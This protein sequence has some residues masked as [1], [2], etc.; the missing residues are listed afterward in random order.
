MRRYLALAIGRIG[1]P[2][3]A[4]VLQQLLV[5]ADSGVQATAA[6]SLGMLRDTSAL[7]QLRLLLG[8]EA[9]SASPAAR[10]EAATAVCRIGGTSAAGLIADYLRRAGGAAGAVA[11][12]EA[13]LRALG[14]AWRL[15]PLA[16]VDAII[17]F[18]TAAQ[19]DVRWHAVYSLARLKSAAA[20]S[21][22]LGATDDS[23]PGVRAIA[24]RELT[25]TYA[26]SAGI[27]RRALSTRV[28]RLT[29][30]P[31]A[32]VRV[33]ALRALGTYGLPD[34]A[35][36][37]IERSDDPDL[38]VRLQA[39]TTL[40]HLGSPEVAGELRERTGNGPF[41]LRRQALISLAQVAP[42]T[43]KELLPTWRAEPDWRSRAAVAEAA[44]LVGG[45]SM[46]LLLESL[47][48]DRDGRVAAAALESL[49][50]VDSAAGLR[51]SRSL[52][53]HNDPV[54]RSV[55]AAQI[56]Q[57]EDTADVD[58][59]LS[60]YL[61]AKTDRIADAR[62]ATI[63]ALGRI[64]GGPAGG[65][66]T[67]AVARR[68]SVCDE[69]LSRR[70]AARGFAALAARCPADS[71]IATGKA[72]GDYREIARTLLLR[73][74]RG[75]GNP[76][77]VLET[78][79]GNVTITLLPAEAPLTVQAFLTLVDRRYFDGGLWHRVVPGFVAQDGDP[80]G[81][82][83]GG[84]G[85]AL[86]DENSRHR[87]RT[88]TVGLALDGPDTG[89]SQF[90]ITL[91]PQPHLD[92]IYPVFGRVEEGMEVVAQLVQGDRLRRMRRR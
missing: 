1:H 82:G 41:A 57:A 80:R 34:L 38:N 77:V 70:A 12:P 87:Y 76:I 26:D 24:V 50:R 23:V 33:A 16:P 25:V 36:A 32:H 54:V 51:V 60:L 65:P 31:D 56:G 22:L 7:D 37:A 13:L 69:Y 48:Q 55:A 18:A 92:A 17:P 59:L 28:R 74:A 84:P 62:V 66:V 81:D 21:T 15:G 27:D 58:R 20:A 6:F 90:F 91:T 10:A 39:L 19:P 9:G 42:A 88:G 46:A 44:A 49:A 85:F 45:D 71:A 89:G 64:A 61:A 78:D 47:S 68:I 73:A 35:G 79:R 67:E 43:A 40:G 29:S 86:R 4:A 5:D 72:L 52:T 3:G 8:D 63:S 2:G 75:G 53:G 14:D 30:D 11:G 83:Y